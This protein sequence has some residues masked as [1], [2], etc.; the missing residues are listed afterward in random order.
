MNFLKTSE[1]KNFIE[2]HDWY[3]DEII[4]HSKLPVIPPPILFQNYK[5]AV[6]VRI[7]EKR[8]LHSSYFI[9]VD[10]L[11]EETAIYIEPK[12]HKDSEKQIHYLQMLFESLKHPDINPYTSGLVEIKWDRQ[13]IEIDKSQ[14]LLTP[15]LVVQFLKIVQQIVRKGLKKS[16]FKV[17]QNLN[18]RIKGKIQVSRTI[19]KNKLQG[20]ELKSLCCYDDFGVDCLENRLLKRA[21]LFVQRYLPTLKHLKVEEFTSKVFNYI[22]PAFE[23]VS[24]DVNH[25]EVTNVKAHVFYKEYEEAIHLGKLIL[26]RFGYNI[27]NIQHQKTIQIPPF[28]IDMSKLFELYVL[29][30]LKEIYGNAVKYHPRGN[31]GET[32]FLLIS[33]PEIYII[34]AKY[35]TK[36]SGEGYKIED[37]RQLSGY[38]RDKNVLKKL[39]IVEKEYQKTVPNCLVIHSDQSS[40]KPLTRPIETKEI[41][42]FVN[43]YKVGI[44]LPE[45]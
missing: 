13:F 15:L 17:E 42:Q 2:H 20:K 6:C 19:Q 24:E 37:I 45:L 4:P 22:F 35:K 34:D 32:D 23:G 27:I 10:W 36:Y 38:A 28:W 18:S 9:G 40:E 43:F 30:K 7:N 21:L 16:Y 12:L 41:S 14:D 8:I 25:Y 31:Y 3:F 33:D 11:N 26:R 44:K 1:N 5:E 39:G 29:G